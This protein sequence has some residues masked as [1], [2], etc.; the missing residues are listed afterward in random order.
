MP[1][2]PRVAVDHEA[3]EDQVA[4]RVAGQPFTVYRYD[5]D[6]TKPVLH[7]IRSAGGVAVTRGYPL[8]PRPGER[9]DH[10]HHVG[11]WLNY[12]HINGH[13]LWNYDGE[14]PLPETEDG[15]VVRQDAIVETT[16]GDQGRLRMRGTWRTPEGAVL[17]EA[18]TYRFGGTGE[19][20]IVDRTTELTALESR[21]ELHD[22]KEGL[23][24][25]R[26]ATGLEHPTDGPTTR[27][28]TDSTVEEVREPHGDSPSGEYYSS[29]SVWGSAVW[30]TQ[31]A[32]V[33][34]AGEVDG[35]EVSVTIMDHPTN[36][37]HP[38]HWHARQYGLF[39]AN[40]LAP[41]VFSRDEEAAM[42]YE[43]AP[44]ESVTFRYRLA[45]D[46]GT[47]HGTTLRDRYERFAG[48]TTP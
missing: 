7:P 22:D 41:P 10:S 17:E 36:P 29:A 46:E 32:W 43:L 28:T 26:V 5:D 12:G 19:T 31:A 42:Q 24:A 13:D 40:P 11:S 3:S 14:P 33:R 25:I 16:S 6:L 20:R 4:V 37:G 27:L 44:G 23:F 18:T 30:G 1:A 8:D 39:A 47:P 45:V 34:L 9:V 15:G 2:S 21:V 38:T 35:T 48:S